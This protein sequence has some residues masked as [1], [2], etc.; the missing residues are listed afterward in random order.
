MADQGNQ[1]SLISR[2]NSNLA[3]IS[4]S[5]SEILHWFCSCTENNY[6]TLILRE[7]CDVIPLYYIGA[8]KSEDSAK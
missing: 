1:K 2:I 3:H 4:C 5:V 7:I 8:P 6:A